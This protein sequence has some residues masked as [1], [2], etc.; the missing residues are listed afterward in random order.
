ME[1]V[2]LFFCCD[3]CRFNLWAQLQN[4]LPPL[5]CSIIII[6]TQAEM[7]NSHEDGDLNPSPS[8]YQL[9]ELQHKYLTSPCLFLLFVTCKMNV[10]I[11]TTP[12]R[13]WRNT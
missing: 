8:P 5:C 2:C 13:S 10:I 7:F 1:F 12:H 11:V 6:K 4:I 9:Y 3:F